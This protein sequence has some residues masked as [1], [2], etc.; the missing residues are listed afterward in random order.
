M[1]FP[2]TTDINRNMLPSMQDDEVGSKL[3]AI[4]TVCIAESLDLD[5]L[6]NYF[7]HC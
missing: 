1:L 4:Y 6:D 2:Y 3:S 7:T 5:S